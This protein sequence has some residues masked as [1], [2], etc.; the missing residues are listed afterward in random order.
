MRKGAKTGLIA[1]SAAVLALTGTVPAAL[2]GG[3]GPSVSVRPGLAWPG[4]PAT[5]TGSGFQAGQPVVLSFDG[6]RL[7]RVIAGGSGGFTGRVTVPS[8][9]KPGGHRLVAAQGSRSAATTVQARLQWTQLGLYAAHRGANWYEHRLSPATVGQ[10]VPLFAGSLQDSPPQVGMVLA[11]GVLVYGTRH[12]A[13]GVSAVTGKAVWTY[14][15]P[16]LLLSG[17]AYDAD[18]GN[19]Y[20]T[21]PDSPDLFAIDA[22]TGR[23]A[24]EI[25]LSSSTGG[26]GLT[27]A[28]GLLY[29]VSGDPV[30]GVIEVQAIDVATRTVRWHTP[31][32]YSNVTPVLYNNTIYVVGHNLSAYSADTGQALWSVPV[33]AADP[34]VGG[35]MPVADAGGIAVGS[36]DGRTR[37]FDLASGRQLWATAPLGGAAGRVRSLAIAEGRVYADYDYTTYALDEATGSTV[38]SKP[39]GPSGL[40]YANGLLFGAITDPGGSYGFTAVVA[41]TG[42][43][44][45]AF[46]AQSRSFAPAIVADGTIYFGTDSVTAYTLPAGLGGAPTK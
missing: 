28:H 10:T 23:V 22:L 29:V 40:T 21:G 30:A 8:T 32:E 25:T 38:W 17:V 12:G 39:G 6:A 14:D 9:A 34:E 24:W 46:P 44:K 13:V 15:V 43:V 11:K 27:L 1:G 4:L 19:V 37:L 31:I 20:L 5:V 2:A 35:G 3:G 26:Q 18:T 36:S 33:S 42:E 41:A 16:D 45:A 7:G